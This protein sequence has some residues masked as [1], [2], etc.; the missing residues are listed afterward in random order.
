MQNPENTTQSSQYKTVINEIGLVE[1]V[2]LDGGGLRKNDGKLRMDLVPMSSLRALARVLGKGCDKYED[3]NWRRGMKWSI[4]QASLLRHLMLWIDGEDIDKESGLNHM[5]HVAANV[6]FL[7]EY[8]E[9]FPQG[10][11]RFKREEK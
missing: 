7:L 10:D 9:V 8:I 6:A 2:K 1:K 3:N 5:D 11:D 4:V